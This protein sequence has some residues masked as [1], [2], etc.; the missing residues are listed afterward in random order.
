MSI[1]AVSV[2]LPILVLDDE[3]EIL[4]AVARDLRRHAIVKTFEDPHAAL[5][6][7]RDTEYS[8]VISDLRMPEMNGLDFLAECAA[9]RPECPRL[10]L[11][12]FA[13]LADIHQSV[14]RAGLSLIM[15]KPWE[16][17]DLQTAVTR[18]LRQNELERENIELRRLALMDGLTGVANHR[19]FWDRLEAEF[20]RAKRYGRPLSLIM[21][22]VDDFKKYNDQFGHRRGD[23]VLHNVAQCLERARRSSDLVARYGGEEFAIILPEISRPVAIDIARRHLDAVQTQ[24]G[25]SLSLGVAAYPDDAP[26]TTELVE[27]ADR[28]LLKAKALGKHRVVNATELKD[29]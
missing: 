3:P 10:L 24:T 18:L 19:Y 25:I 11:T 28:A 15:S 29:S 27:A 4:K 23:E 6:S 7:F 5:E 9:V 16:A 8:L 20:S 26:S 2:H 21:C 22:D 12:A 1:G 13:D 17:E 14:N